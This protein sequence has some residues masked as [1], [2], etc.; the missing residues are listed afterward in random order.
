M[1]ALPKVKIAVVGTGLIGPRH[2]QAVQKDGEAELTCIVD[3]NPAAEAVAGRLGVP[4]Y[5]NVEAMLRTERCDAAIV[6]TP[7]HTHVAISQE[8]LEGGVHVLVEKPI[9]TDGDSA[10]QLVSPCEFFAI[11]S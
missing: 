8:L 4:L 9:S 7:N 10:K 11:S 5:P 1:P 2:A 3:P 6:C